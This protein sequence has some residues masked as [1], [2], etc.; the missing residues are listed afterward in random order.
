[1]KK[2]KIGLMIFIVL[3]TLFFYIAPPLAYILGY[4]SNEFAIGYILS[5]MA[6]KGLGDFFHNIADNIKSKKIDVKG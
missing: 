1:M 2:E 6:C 5:M 4:M 3:F